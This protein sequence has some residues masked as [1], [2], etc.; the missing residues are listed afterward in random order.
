MKKKGCSAE[1]APQRD[2][3]LLRAFKN[4]LH[5][6]GDVPQLVFYRRIAA[7]PSS[8]FWVS[9]KRAAE[10]VA[11]IM[12]GDQLVGMI[13]KRRE[14]FFEI[15]RRVDQLRCDNPKLSI[16]EATFQVVNSPAP[17]FYIT[18]KSARQLLYKIRA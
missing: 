12:K 3:E 16:A 17:E 5:L 7:S 1:F 18:E 10:V 13:P 15:F 11:K 6:L 2:A 8:R 14:M 4:C 9:E